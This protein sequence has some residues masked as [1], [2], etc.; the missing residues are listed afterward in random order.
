MCGLNPEWEVAFQRL[1]LPHTPRML[2]GPT[3]RLPPERRRLAYAPQQ[4][5]LFPHL[6]VRDN[7]AF[8][9]D[10][11]SRDPVRS[12]LPEQIVA[13][14]HLEDLLER[15]PRT[16]S[17]GERQRVSLARALAVPDAE[18]LLLDEPFAGVDRTLRDG[19]IPLLR[20]LCSAR[21]LPVVSG[22]HDVDEVFLLQAEV[23]RLKE[24]RV[25]SQGTPGAVLA[26]EVGR[27]Q[28]ALRIAP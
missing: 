10:L 11:R 5:A 20:S 25:I 22:T 23:V 28:R 17:G 27:V 18:L 26:D 2:Q 3:M 8:T 12:T 24:G 13:L 19:L 6:S 15:Y 1:S 7:I 9:R 14:M 16:L 21:G 4:A